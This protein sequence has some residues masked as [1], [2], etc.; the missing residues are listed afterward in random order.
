MPQVARI[1]LESSNLE[2]LEKVSNE[3][4]E[5]GIR[6]GVNIKGPVPLPTKKLRIVTRKAPSGQGTHTFDKWDMKLHRRLID[7]DANERT[8]GQLTRLKI[9]ESVSIE[10]KLRS[11]P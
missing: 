9:P 11:R 7:I 4:K 2:E 10:I 3:I 1:K 5:L 8:M 6:T